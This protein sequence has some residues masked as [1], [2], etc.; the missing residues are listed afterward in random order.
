MKKFLLAGAAAIAFASGA[1]AADLGVPRGAVAAAVVAPVFNWTGVSLGAHLGAVVNHDRVVIPAYGPPGIFT[2][3]PTSLMI[4][5]QLGY[6]YQINNVVLGVE[7]DLSYL[8]GA[9]SGLSGN[10][11]TELFRVRPDYNGSIRGRLGFAADRALFYVTGG[12]AFH[13]LTGNFDNP[14][15]TGSRRYNYVGGTVGAGIEYAVTNNWTVRGEYL[16]GI[17]GSK[18]A[19]FG[20]PVDIRPQ[21][22]TFRVG[23]NYLFSTGPSAVVARY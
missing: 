14:N 3:S 12:V 17:Y 1:Q 5:G 19:V 7:A 22:H 8:A 11:G 6:N 2:R 10:G 18:R 13:G 23:V 4:G 21:T 16:Y 20:G 9:Q 15:L